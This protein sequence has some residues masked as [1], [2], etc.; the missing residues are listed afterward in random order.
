MSNLTHCPLVVAESVDTFIFRRLQ[1]LKKFV[2]E[3]QGFP[4]GNNSGIQDW[5]ALYDRTVSAETEANGILEGGPSAIFGRIGKHA[6]AI[7][8][9]IDLIP[10]EFGVC[11]V[12]SAFAIILHVRKSH[13]KSM[14][15]STK[16][17]NS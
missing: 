6:D 11:I 16:L 12:K 1:R 17:M 3:D 9:W 5:E 2:V 7:D 8:P 14:G 10:N 4:L 13:L 15:Y